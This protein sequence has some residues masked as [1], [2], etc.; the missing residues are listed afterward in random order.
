MKKGKVGPSLRLL[1]ENNSGGIL[2]LTHTTRKE[3]Q[4]K[5]SSAKVAALDTK[6]EGLQV[7]SH[8]GIFE[9]INGLMIWKMALKIQGA[10]G[11]SG[12]NADC[13]WTLLRKRIFGEEAVD[14]R[15][16]LAHLAKKM[17]TEKCQGIVAPVARR[18]ISLDKNSGVRPVAIGEAFTRILGNCMMSVTRD[19]VKLA[20]GHLQEYSML[21]IKQEARQQ[22]IL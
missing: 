19:D 21:V 9:E 3:L 1:Q 20:A 6:I 13:L 10:A 7:D 2:P 11:P 14:L 16:A 17:A 18:L 5:H 8:E 15:K 22:F 12:L 4:G